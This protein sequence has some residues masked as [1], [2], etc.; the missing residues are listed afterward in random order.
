MSE[1]TRRDFVKSAMAGVAGA[2][3]M[4][5]FPG[6]A[7]A[8]AEGETTATQEPKKIVV[9]IGGSP[10]G[11]TVKLADSFAQGAQ[12][13]GH[14][15]TSFFLGDKDIRCCLGCDDCRYGKGCV[16]K[17][18]MEPIYEA[19]KG[20]D[21][22]V[23]ASALRYWSITGVI[24]NVIERMYATCS[25]DLNPPKG[26]YE[27]YPEVDCALLMTAADDNWWTFDQAKKYYDYA[28]VNYLG[29]HDKGRVL[30]GGCGGCGDPKCIEETGHLATAYE[31]GKNVY[32]G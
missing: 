11:N 28:V 22:I 2:A 24:K 26:R 32:A 8:K 7:A 10:N 31:F 12:E 1:M 3:A 16:Q 23:F 5:S 14:T 13:A 20:A 4:V 29:W 6:F 19:L 15:V 27:K 30:A 18:D 9:L 17:D 25:E 21:M